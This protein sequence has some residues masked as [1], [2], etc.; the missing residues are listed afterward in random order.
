MLDIVLH[1]ISYILASGTGGSLKKFD[2]YLAKYESILVKLTGNKKTDESNLR[3]ILILISQ[4]RSL[5]AESWGGHEKSLFIES[6][7]IMIH[8]M[9]L[10]GFSTSDLEDNFYGIFGRR[11]PRNRDSIDF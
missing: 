8:K 1:E 2:D 9:K 10:I 3:E 11:N 6:T 7:Q 4:R 5:E